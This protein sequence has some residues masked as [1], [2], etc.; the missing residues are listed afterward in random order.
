MLVA[1]GATEE[2]A[3]ACEIISYEAPF[4]V[5]YLVAQLVRQASAADESSSHVSAQ[6]IDPADTAGGFDA[7]PALARRTIETF[8]NTGEMIEPPP[9]LPEE[10]TVRA[11]CFVSIKTREGELRGCIGTID[12]AKDTLAEE[13]IWNAISAATRDPRFP[14][15]AKNELPNLKYSVDVMSAPESC[16]VADLDPKI[17]GVIVEDDGGLRRGLLLPNLK[18]IDSATQQ[19]ELAARKAGIGPDAS[20]KLSRFRADRYSE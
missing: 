14:P 4:G 18:G 17:Y 7:I 10:L 11:G 9:D 12:P 1:I 15:V 20:V 13:I 6:S 2:I 3:P 5:G 8:V 16:T 19:V